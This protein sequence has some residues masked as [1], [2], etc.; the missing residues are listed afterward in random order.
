MPCKHVREFFHVFP[1][2]YLEKSDFLPI[3]ANESIKVIVMEKRNL[4]RKEALERLQKS[5][6]AKKDYI[7]E[8]R[9]ALE[10]NLFPFISV[11]GGTTDLTD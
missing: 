8:T 4:T 11:F 6:K 3:F 10:I 7:K 5:I 2:K 9:V 1:S